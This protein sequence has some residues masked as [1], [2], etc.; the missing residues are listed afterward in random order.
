MQVLIKSLHTPGRHC[1]STGLRNL[2]AFHGLNWSE[3][4]CFGL[5]AGLGIWYLKSKTPPRMIHVRSADIEERFFMNIGM[6]VT[7]EKYDTP[8]QSHD[9]LIQKIDSGVPAIVQTDIFYLPYYN[10]STHFPGHVI[11]V[12]GYDSLKNVFYVTDTERPELIEVQFED[13]AKAQFC[14]DTFFNIRGNCIAPSK[15]T[16]IENISS[17]IRNAIVYNSNLILDTS[18]PMQG[19]SGLSMFLDELEL[20]TQFED[21]QWAFRFAYQ[22]IEKRGTGGGG[23]RVMYQNFLEEATSIVPEIKK[24]NLP[25]LMNTCA[26][27]WT[28]LALALKEA[29]EKD[30]PETGCI[31]LR[32]EELKEAEQS[33]HSTALKL[34]E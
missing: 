1:A 12:W 31:R 17:A 4:M 34:K 18:I 25:Q 33:Y 7:W 6:P 19:I 30:K 14:N 20:W 2:A 32:L 16:P 8:Q 28:N 9:A 21:W 29:S 26:V 24:L 27:A 15:I 22:V 5:G 11:T 3:A 10:S 23:F 13:M